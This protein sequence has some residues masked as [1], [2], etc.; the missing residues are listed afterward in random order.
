M[1]NDSSLFS[2]D[3]WQTLDIKKRDIE[4]LHT[5]L[6]ETETPL[7]ITDLAAV[8]VDERIRAER[9]K[10]LKK[11]K[12]S[13]KFFSPKES[14]AVG[15]QLT[16]PAL[17][18][19]KGKVTAIRAGDNPEVG[20]F[21]VLTVLMEDNSKREFA[22]RLAEHALNEVDPAGDGDT[23][24]DPTAIIR[25]FGPVIAAD[26]EAALRAGDELVS[27]AGHWFPRALLVDVNMGHLN[28]AEAILDMAEGEPLPPDVIMH[29]IDLPS[30]DNA[31]LTEFSLNYALQEDPRFDEVGAAGQVLWC[32]ERLEPEEVRSVPPLLQ[33]TPV[34]LDRSTLTEEMLTLEAKLDDELSHITIDGKTQKSATV[35]LLYPHWRLGTLPVSERI[36][37]F[38]PTAYE[39]PRIRFTLVDGKTG[40]KMPGWVVKDYRYVF[41]L[42]EWYDTQGLI[43]GSLIEIRHGK[44]PGEVIIEAQTHR[45]KRDWVRTVIAGTDGGLVFATLKQVINAKFDDRMVLAVPDAKALDRAWELTHAS[46]QTFEQLVRKLMKELTKLNSQ[47]HVHAQ[48]LYS[49]V[50]IVRRCPP[51]PLFSLLATQPWADHVGDLHFRLTD[52]ISEEEEV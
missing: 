9:E 15:D 29:D 14:Y 24:D 19:Q 21:D 3:Y 50:N 38:F 4:F 44:N 17:D 42:K 52:K 22:G 39:A 1:N 16:F 6:F 45:S 41:G 11:R 34:D 25:D 2:A 18:W 12:G 32:L 23:E 20:D 48:E 36:R 46:N 28:L 43:P 31:N 49:V 33:Y 40:D 10:M 47:E 8:F 35:S 13:G 27:M 26:L 37:S 5:H 7:T 51:A 30:G